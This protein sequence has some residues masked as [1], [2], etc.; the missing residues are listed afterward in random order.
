M[1]DAHFCPSTVFG[2]ESKFL[3]NLSKNKTSSGG[4]EGSYTKHS[5]FNQSSVNLHRQIFQ[6][7]AG[8]V[9]SVPQTPTLVLSEVSYSS[10]NPMRSPLIELL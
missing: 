1:I 10:Q 7:L 5:Y 8:T 2:K 3:Q 4:R 9:V 6:S